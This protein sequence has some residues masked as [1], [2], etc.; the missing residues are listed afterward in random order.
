M[1][2]RRHIS[3]KLGGIP[4][5]RL[6]PAHVQGLYAA[7][8][9]EGKSP[10]TRRMAHCVLRRALRDALRWNM[11][12]QNPCD[13][14][15]PPALARCEIAPLTQQQAR[16]LLE[17]AQDNRYHALYVLAVASGLRLGELFG[18]QWEDVDLHA[19]TVSVR[20]TLA[21]LRGKLA[22]TDPKTKRSRRQ[23][24]LPGVAIAA[25]HEHRKRMMAEGHA[26]SPF[27]FV[28][29]TGGPLRRSKFHR[30][31]FK[32]L[33]KR[34]GLPRIR[35]HDLRHTSATLL[36]SAGVHPKIVQERLGHS[37]IAVT[38]DVYS[39]VLPGMQREAADR[40]AILAPSRAAR[41]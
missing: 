10:A 23:I 40:G 36:L 38:M 20:H 27:V 9:R 28:N 26:G 29:H 22:L 34:A 3:P 4:L 39:H 35:F 24:E 18:L 21:E 6:T 33:L 14:V 11:I 8:E 19:G 2:V 30:H 31:E 37:Q 15:S 41:A 13:R 32:P 16:T 17:A 5:S 12:A 7:L 25:L 1:N